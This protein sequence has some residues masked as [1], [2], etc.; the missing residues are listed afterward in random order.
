MKQNFRGKR[1]FL[2]LLVLLCL[3]L[4]LCRSSLFNFQWL[5]RQ[6]FTFYDYAQV[7]AFSSS[8]PPEEIVIVGI[9]E[10]DLKIFTS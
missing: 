9:T 6:E 3:F 7:R 2:I 8:L 4:N 10:E 5:Q 1:G